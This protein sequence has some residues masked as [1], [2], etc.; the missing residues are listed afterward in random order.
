MDALNGLTNWTNYLYFQSFILTPP[1]ICPRIGHFS[2][3]KWGEGKEDQKVYVKF[4]VATEARKIVKGTPTKAH[5][6][7][8]LFVL[9]S[10]YLDSLKRK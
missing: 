2:F 4:N 1:V 5:P 7:A 8:L 9:A 3:T 10:A 6:Q